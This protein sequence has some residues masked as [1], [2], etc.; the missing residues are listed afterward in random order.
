MALQGIDVLRPETAEGSKPFVELH[1]RLRS[2]AVEASLRF[3]SRL[4]EAGVFQHAQVLRDRR[5]RQSKLALDLADGTLRREQ[6]AQ[7]GPSIGLGD[8]GE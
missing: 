8:D 6:Q 5:L 2:Q 1:E 4:D 3:D 7:D